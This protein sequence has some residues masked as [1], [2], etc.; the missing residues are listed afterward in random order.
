LIDSIAGTSTEVIIPKLAGETLVKFADSTGNFSTNAASIVLQTPAQKADTL[1]VKN[2]REDQISPTPFTG[3]KT[4]TE[5]DAGLDALQLTSSG[6]DINSSGSYQFASTL[7][8]EGVFSL[9]LQRY[10]VTRGVRP[11]DLIDVWPDVDARSDWDGAVIDDVNASLSVRITND[12]PSGSPTWGSWVA[13]KNGTF[14]G[15]AFQF[16]TDMTS[17]DTTENILVDQLGYEARFDIRSE[18]ST[19]L[20]AS[21]TS[22]K[23]VSFSSPFWTGTSA[24]GGGATAY[25]PSVSVNVFGLASGDF[26]DMGTVTGSQF[27]LTIRNSGGSAINKNFSW[28]AVGYGR[29]A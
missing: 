9:D 14:R 1:L 11:S 17:A 16:K 28:T 22:A 2:Q 21:G 23:T 4:N 8:L 10:F 25:L 3:S 15:R 6:G 24:L 5:Y 20:T 12:N 29:G 27:T 26:I 19:G 13:L 18:Q 7:D